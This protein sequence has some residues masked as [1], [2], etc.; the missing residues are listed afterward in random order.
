VI[1]SDIGMPV[2]DGYQFVQRVRAVDHTRELPAL[3]LTAY[4]RAEDRER[5]LA[6]G[7]HDHLAK[8]IH[9]SRLVE[10]VAALVRARHERLDLPSTLE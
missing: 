7:F 8:P 4:A 6:S 10:A 1:V 5:A 3:A 9:P 2:E